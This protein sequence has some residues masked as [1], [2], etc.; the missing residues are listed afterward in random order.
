MKNSA[1]NR[2]LI[3][4]TIRLSAVGALSVVPVLL[5]S[6]SSAPRAPAA[7]P[8]AARSASQGEVY[9]APAQRGTSNARTLDAYKR[10]VARAVY[11]AHPDTLHRGILPP[12]LRG[13][14]VVTVV[15]DP[16]ANVIEVKPLRVPS[17]A[18]ETLNIV[19]KML[20][21]ASLPAPQQLPSSAYKAG[22]IEFSETFLFT[23]AMTYQINSASEGQARE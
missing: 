20:R 13:V 3:N 18:P 12:L 6:C 14:T 5:S 11:A 8:T 1:N 19:R 23:D 21:A 10:D 22:K 2:M 4:Y 15:L 17:Q 9:S 16:N 7:A